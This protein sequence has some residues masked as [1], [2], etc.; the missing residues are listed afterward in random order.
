LAPAIRL[1]I[2]SFCFF[3]SSPEIAFPSRDNSRLI[4]VPSIQK[5][6]RSSFVDFFTDPCESRSCSV[7]VT[8]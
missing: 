1:S 5:L 6:S 7:R 8:R 3:N 2:S 4:N